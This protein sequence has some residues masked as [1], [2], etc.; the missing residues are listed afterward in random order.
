MRE[1]LAVQLREVSPRQTETP[2]TSTPRMVPPDVWSRLCDLA[3]EFRAP[4]NWVDQMLAAYG[5][6]RSIRP[7]RT[8][9]ERGSRGVQWT[10]G[11]R[12]PNKRIAETFGVSLSVIER[13]NNG[14]RRRDVA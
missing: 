10:F 11:I 2:P 5:P 8:G 12:C 7:E 4:R 6:D 13:I 14:G 3:V 1:E 9:G